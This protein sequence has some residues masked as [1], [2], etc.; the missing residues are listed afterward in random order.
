M[1]TE[2][3]QA[4]AVERRFFEQEHR[5]IQRGVGRI[6]EVAAQAERFSAPDLVAALDDLIRWLESSLEPHGA[7]E[8]QWLYP[9]LDQLAG[10]GWPGRL[11]SFDHWQIRERI[12]ALKI[13]RDN[14]AHGTTHARLRDLPGHLYGLDAVIRCHL[15]RE[16][17][18]LLPILDE[19]A[20]SDPGPTVRR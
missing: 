20:M 9:R 18:F 16:E 17:R 11:L 19:P 12:D 15:E 8:E 2:R 5:E 3:M 6:T 7:W 1:V 14:L 4:G 10:S 13:E